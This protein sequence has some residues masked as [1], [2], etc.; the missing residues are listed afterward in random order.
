LTGVCGYFIAKSSPEKQLFLHIRGMDSTTKMLLFSDKQLLD[1]NFLRTDLGRLYLAIPFE[2]LAEKIPKPKHA[3]SGRGCKPWFDVQGGIALQFLKHYHN[4]SDQLLIERLN[5]DWSMQLFCRISLGPTERIEDK[6]IVSSWRLYLGE[7]MDLQ[8]LQKIFASHWK[9]HMEDTNI[10]SQ[11]AT[12][13]ESGI[14]YPTD[15]K[16][17][18]GCCEQVYTIIQKQRKQLKLRKSRC[19][20]EKKRTTF[21][22]YQKLRKKSK[23]KE[24]KLRKHLLKHLFRLLELLK[25]LHAKYKFIFSN[26]TKKRLA[27]IEKIYEQQHQ[28]AY[29]S[30]GEIIQD[31]I[32]SI[33]KWYV[34]PIV[35]GKES[36]PVEFG[37]KVNKLQV[38]GIN[39][40]E[41]LSF[42]AFNESTR[43]E[44]GIYLQR[45]LFGKCTHQSADAIYATNKNRRYAHVQGIQTNFVPKGKQKSEY[46]EQAG[47]IRSILNKQ[48]STVL[49]GSFGNEKNHYMLQKSKARTQ[50]TDIAWIFFGMMTANA[51]IIAQRIEKQ[52]RFREAS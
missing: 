34:R 4:L 45:K 46:V 29:G 10:G 30:P 11:D 13:Y 3:L 18:W 28:R 15:I 5:T 6:N 8:E 35:R 49:E 40:I 22:A 2:K 23:R 17:L 14:G 51:S 41:H 31:R 26:R 44:Q 43:F 12:C 21:L 36:K 42:D 50:A 52:S 20:F 25:E 37:A 39:F 38:D 48:R 27:V 7:H 33:H 9:P 47:Q 19:N 1:Q 32:V 24:K 16:L